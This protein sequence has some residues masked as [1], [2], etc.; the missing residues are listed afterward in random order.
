MSDQTATTAVA[1]NPPAVVTQTAVLPPWHG[2]IASG[3]GT[4]ASGFIGH[5]PIT[6]PPL[7]CARCQGV[8]IACGERVVVNGPAGQSL[9]H[10]CWGCAGFD[11]GTLGFSRHAEAMALDGVP[12]WLADAPR[13][14][15]ADWLE[16]AGRPAAAAFVRGTLSG[17]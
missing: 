4:F 5:A 3:Y 17:G 9:G 14:V 6:Q 16:E 11:A 1:S 15:V 8:I 7:R 10:F 2:M 13:G 12:P